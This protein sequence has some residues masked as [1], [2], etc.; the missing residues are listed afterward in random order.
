QYGTDTTLVNP[1]RVGHTFLGWFLNEDGTGTVITVLGANDF[2]SDI[3]LYAAW[4]ANTYTI[5]FDVNGGNALVPNTQDVVFGNTFTLP[6]PTREGHT[7]N[8]WIHNGNSFTAGTWD[9][10]NDVTL[11]ADWTANTYTITFDVNGGDAL[12]PNTQEVTFEQNFTLPT[13]TRSGFT[14]TGWYNGTDSIV[15]TGTWNIANDVTLIASW[16]A[17]DYTI[18]F[19]VAGGDALSDQTVTF[20]QSFTL[21]TPTRT[22]HTFDGWLHNGNPFTAGTW[23]IAND[24]TIVATWTANIYTITFNVNGGNTL[25]PGTQDVVF[26]TTF[27][28]PTPTREGHTFNSWTHNENPF[29]VGTWDIANDVTLVASWTANTY[30]ITFNVNGGNTLVP[31][32]Q[33][34]VFGESY[35]LPTP[36]REG[37]TFA[38]WYNGTDSIALT[39][40]WTI[41]NDVTLVATW[42]ANNYTITLDVNGGNA[43]VPNTQNV[44]FGQPYTLPTPT[45]TGFTFAG[46]YNGTDLIP[47]DGTWDITNDT[48]LI[49]QWTANTY[50]ITFNVNGGN[51][52]VP[53]TQDVVFGESYTLPTPTRNFYNFG[54]WTYNS[55][56]IAQTGIWEINTNVT[57]VASWTPTTQEIFQ[58]VSMGNAHGVAID[59]QGRL[60]S[61]GSNEDGRTGL[62]ISIGN[63]SQPTLI[64][65][66]EIRFYRVSASNDYTIA[67]DT[68]GRLWSWG[69]NNHGR[70]GLGIEL[71]YTLIPTLI[72]TGATEFVYISTSGT[73][74]S[75]DSHTIAIDTEGRLWSWGSN[76]HGKAGQGAGHQNILIPTEI[77]T[78][79]VRF[80][81]VA[82]GHLHSVAIDT[83][84]GLWSWGS[85]GLGRTGL[86]TSAGNTLVPTRIISTTNYQFVLV[87]TSN[88]HT[89]AIDIEGNVWSW[90]SNTQGQTGLGLTAGH[91]LDPTRIDVGNVSFLQVDMGNFHN[92][93]LDTEGR[94]WSFG[95]NGSGAT[96][97]GIT[98]GNT[99]YPEMLDTGTLRFNHISSGSNNNMAIDTYGRIWSWGSNANGRTGQ[100]VTSGSNSVPILNLNL[101]N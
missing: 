23:D 10:A 80:I 16:T 34:V 44:T 90:G 70:T 56:V 38:G 18:T 50:T 22:G 93:L 17:N 13:P 98:S 33:D 77:D 12:V 48:T 92:I 73:V 53:D 49:A 61:W 72:D 47:L 20:G 75:T 84:G 45:R 63:T 4:T 28:L 82:S 88:N 79:T 85:N 64:D 76:I 29:T 97:L 87:R 6:A 59:Y 3:I 2:T 62:G 94:L 9:I 95:G 52:L 25:V 15:L 60:W 31:G 99:I 21:P 54:G 7:F 67:I 43:L 86:G 14:F 68:Y 27:T 1:T 39:G 40:T 36:T 101:L 5:T 8:G 66:N 19:D 96:G 81:S 41:A 24:I 91:T 37:H 83:A 58:Y 100:G 71:G 26:G 74:L 32:T 57:L 42:T 11:V 69:S 30:T 55:L 89:I 35:T 65:T 51:T 78:G 46:W